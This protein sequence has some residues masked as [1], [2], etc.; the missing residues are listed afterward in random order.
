MI[1]CDLIRCGLVLIMVLPGLP[2]APLIALLFAVTLV[3]A[4][5]TSAVRGLP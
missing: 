4:P 3:G 2:V 5:F 1:A